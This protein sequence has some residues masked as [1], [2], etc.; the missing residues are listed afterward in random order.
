MDGGGAGWGLDAA[1]DAAN[2]TLVEAGLLQLLIPVADQFTIPAAVT[3]INAVEDR[4]VAFGFASTAAALGILGDPANNIGMP[5]GYPGLHFVTGYGLDFIGTANNDTITLTFTNETATLNS[6]GLSTVGAGATAG[7]R[8][9]EN[10][11]LAAEV[12][13][14]PGQL[15]SAIVALTGGGTP[16]D[17]G[18]RPH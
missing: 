1:T 18:V 14:G 4:T 6:T 16:T 12:P 9:A 3:K 15:V 11:D 2:T 7:V 10:V 13:V 8:L 17:V 5:S